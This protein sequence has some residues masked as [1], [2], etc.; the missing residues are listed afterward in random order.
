MTDDKPTELETF[1]ILEEAAK[2]LKLDLANDYSGFMKSCM[3]SGKSAAACKGEWESKHKE[4]EMSADMKE[5]VTFIQQ[6]MKAGKTLKQGVEEWTKMHAEKEPEG[7]KPEGKEP[8]IPGELKPIMSRLEA[9]ENAK[10]EEIKVTLAA[11][12]VEVKKVDP[13]FD[14]KKFL[15]PFA[16]NVVTAIT[17]IDTY[18]ETVKHFKETLPEIESKMHLGTSDTTLAHRK[19]LT[20]AMFGKDDITAI[21]KEI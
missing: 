2:T 8:E 11:H 7:K 21:I 18:M 13:T 1:Q 12:I 20:K 16:D 10:K 19:E 5:Y 17:A 9:L 3:I 6:S 4:T 15:A 14:E